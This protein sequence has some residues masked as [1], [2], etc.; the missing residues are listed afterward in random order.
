MTTATVAQLAKKH[1]GDWAGRAERG[2]LPTD[3]PARTT[4]ALHLI[5]K[6]DAPQSELRIG[7]VGVPRTHPDYFDIVV[8]NAIFGGLFNS[9]VNLNLREAH[10]YTYSAFSA[11]DWRRGAG[12]FVVSTAVKTDTTASSIREVIKEME[13]IRSERVAADELSLATSY[14]DGVFPIRF[15][16][17]AAVAGSLANQVIYGFPLDYFYSYRAHI[18]RH[19][20]ISIRLG[21]RRSSLVTRR[22]CGASSRS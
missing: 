19:G 4:R 5:E 14:L 13:R 9:R 21:C 11:F 20:D 18:R 7:H 15:E 2:K 10:A 22:R 8:M 6:A 1:L 16:T 17:T 12:P 3:K